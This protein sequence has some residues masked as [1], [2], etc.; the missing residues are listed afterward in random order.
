MK[1]ETIKNAALI[2]STV[3][4]LVAGTSAYHSS[5]AV[6]QAQAQPVKLTCEPVVK[7]I[8]PDPIHVE[9]VKK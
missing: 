9:F 7:I 4:S 2:G 6:T 3:L 8:K 1:L 5:Q